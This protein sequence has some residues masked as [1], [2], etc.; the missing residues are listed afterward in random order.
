MEKAGAMIFGGALLALGGVGGCVCITN[1][2]TGAEPLSIP[3]ALPT[4]TLGSNLPRGPVFDAT[5]GAP[6]RKPTQTPVP[7]AT[8]PF[9][10]YYSGGQYQPPQGKGCD[11]SIEKALEEQGRGS[12][13]D[14][15]DRRN[16]AFASIDFPPGLQVPGKEIV[17]H[18]MCVLND[19]T[20]YVLVTDSHGQVRLVQLIEDPQNPRHTKDSDGVHKLQCFKPNENDTLFGGPPVGPNRQTAVD[21]G[22]QFGPC[23]SISPQNVF[24]L[25]PPLIRQHPGA[26]WTP[27]RTPQVVRK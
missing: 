20:G 11:P 25:N 21:M 24:T 27:T 8:P 13:K 23:V 16:R 6:V 10:E 17:P 3:T 2:F 19:S 14:T 1:Q 18:K 12:R 4:G 22:T 5:Q 26:G 9:T 7:T 15:E